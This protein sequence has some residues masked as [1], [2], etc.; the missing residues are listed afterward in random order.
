VVARRG[1]ETV[2]V[3][4][5]TEQEIVLL[6]VRTE[7]VTFHPAIG[8]TTLNREAAR[9]IRESARMRF[10]EASPASRESVSRIHVWSLPSGV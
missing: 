7:Q 9:T 5:Q 2:R 4:V 8:L 10:R 1:L 6:S 3:V